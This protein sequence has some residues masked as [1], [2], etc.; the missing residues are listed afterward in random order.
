[1]AETLTV[2]CLQIRGPLKRTLQSTNPCESMIETVRRTSRNVKRWQ[3][4][5]ETMARGSAAIAYDAP[6][7]NERIRDGENGTL[8]ATEPAA[9]R[10]KLVSRLGRSVGRKEGPCTY[11]LSDQ[12]HWQKSIAS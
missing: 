12:Q 10:P 2:T 9:P 3:S 8:L 5:V 1:M 6:T 11:P 7:M 4:G